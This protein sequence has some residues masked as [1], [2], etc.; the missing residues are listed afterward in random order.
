MKDI[1]I[2][3]LGL[4]ILGLFFSFLLGIA[5]RKLRTEQ[6]PLLSQILSILPGIN[7]GACG[8]S[9]CQAFAQ[10][11]IKEGKA[12]SV[13]VPGGKEVNEKIARIIGS[14]V[15][16]LSLRKA[17]LLCSQDSTQRIFSSSYLGPSKCSIAHLSG[18]GLA[19]KYGCLGFGD[20]VEVCKFGALKMKDGLPVVDYSK[21]TGCGA[22]VKACPRN[23]FI[24]VDVDNFKDIYIP[25]CSNPEDALNTKKVCRVGCI[26]CGVCVKVSKDSP[27]YLKDFLA[28]V[29]FKKFDLQ[30]AQTASQ[31]CPTKVIKKVEI[32][33]GKENSQE[34][35]KGQDSLN[36]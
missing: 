28:R 15:E 33:G 14:E 29:D 11:V 21:C 8:F 4:G 30:A 23:L 26:G 32:G 3:T 36:E 18:A 34:S 24:L 13:C 12:S 10:A 17:V 5:Q 6:D 27:F 9:S 19:C 1:I 25:R 7:C 22:C 2:A 16:D 35:D 20:C 31:R